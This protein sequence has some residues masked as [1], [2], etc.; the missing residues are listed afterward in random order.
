MTGAEPSAVVRDVRTLF[1]AGAVGGLSDRQLLERFATRRDDGAQAAFAALVDRHGAMVWGACR[2]ILHDPHE[3]AA[4]FQ[5]TFLVLVRRA[6]AGSIRVDDALLSAEAAGATLPARLAEST[7]RAVLANVSGH[8][9]IAGT[10][11]ATVVSLAEGAG[12]SMVVNPLKWAAAT[13][14]ALGVAAGGSFVHA[15]QP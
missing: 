15:L 13:V 9:A 14:V 3:A 4:A 11:S 6:G 5:A 12:S 1:S 10:V 7:A 8:T 2:R